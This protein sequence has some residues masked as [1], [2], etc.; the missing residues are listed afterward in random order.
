ME[1]E[2]KIKIYCMDRAKFYCV[3][4]AKSKFH[5][6]GG[7]GQDQVPL[8]GGGGQDQDLLHGQF[9]GQPQLGQEEEEEEE[10]KQD[11]ITCVW[12]IWACHLCFTCHILFLFEKTLRCFLEVNCP[13]CVFDKGRQE[14]NIKYDMLHAIYMRWHLISV[15][16]ASNT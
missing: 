8:H 5:C 4:Q 13:K 2:G 1:E 16:K 11:L 12:I 15:Q 9:Q 10:K 7:K 3:G 6:M 14:R